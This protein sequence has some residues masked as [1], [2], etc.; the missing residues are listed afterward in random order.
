MATLNL[1]LSLQIFKILKATVTN[2]KGRIEKFPR[3]RDFLSRVQQQKAPTR[4]VYRN[5]NPGF[6]LY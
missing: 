3:R 6:I 1:K 5:A 4:Y 2:P